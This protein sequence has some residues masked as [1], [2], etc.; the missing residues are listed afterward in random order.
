[1]I[2][3]SIPELLKN[4]NSRYLLVNV[5]AHRAREI[6]EYAEE[7]EISLE[8]KPVSLAI[9]EIAD[10]KIQCHIDE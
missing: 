2:Y 4:V 8:K 6:A 1:M 5:I 3:P 7:N 10:G 9:D